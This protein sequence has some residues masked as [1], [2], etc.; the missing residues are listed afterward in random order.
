[1]RACY[2]AAVVVSCFVVLGCGFT[3]TQAK[4]IEKELATALPLQSTSVQV[5]D[6]L[7]NRRIEH[8]AYR[9]DSANGGSVQAIIRDQSQ[10]AIVQ[11]HVSILFHFD[12]H[13]RLLAYEVTP[14]H[15]GP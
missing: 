8:S 13:D 6:Y 5:L 2:P 11:T 3:E 4:A 10:F 1:M 9:R 14:T 12:D 7:N 15:T